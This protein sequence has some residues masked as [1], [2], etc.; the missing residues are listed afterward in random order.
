MCVFK[1]LVY[2][3]MKIIYKNSAS[4]ENEKSKNVLSVS[5]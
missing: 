3:F 2:I 1:N 4:I 5:C